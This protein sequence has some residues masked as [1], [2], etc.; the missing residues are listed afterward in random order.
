MGGERERG[1]EAATL[2]LLKPVDVL[3]KRMPLVH[4]L[5]WVWFGQLLRFHSSTRKII[6]IWLRIPHKMRTHLISMLSTLIQ[7]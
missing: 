5:V 7:V 2:R 4:I 6:I 1:R 3:Q